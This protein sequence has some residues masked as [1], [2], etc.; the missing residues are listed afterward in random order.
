MY[1]L[2]NSF[3]DIFLCNRTQFV[4]YTMCQSL[5]PGREVIGS[6]V[7]R[8]KETE[9]VQYRVFFENRR[10]A[11]YWTYFLHYG[12]RSFREPAIKAWR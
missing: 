6:Y 5:T 7:K 3:I 8:N 12:T 10:L 1:L 2:F 9:P 4:Y 11:I